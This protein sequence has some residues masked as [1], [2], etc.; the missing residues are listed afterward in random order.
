MPIIFVPNLNIKNL[1][2]VYNLIQFIEII[3]SNQKL[4]KFIIYLIKIYIL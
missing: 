4:R 3:I 2:H 1:L